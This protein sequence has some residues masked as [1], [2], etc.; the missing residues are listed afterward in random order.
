MQADERFLPAK[1]DSARIKYLKKSK[2]ILFNVSQF[3]VVLTNI[4]RKLFKKPIKPKNKW[5]QN[6]PLKNLCEYFGKEKLTH[7]LLDEIEKVYAIISSTSLILFK[8]CQEVSKNISSELAQPEASDENQ[9]GEY[10]V[11]FKKKIQ[12]SI[13]EIENV[14][15][16]IRQSSAESIQKIII[17]LDEAF[18]KAGTIELLKRNFNPD[19]IKNLRGEVSSII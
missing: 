14:E 18:Q 19:K 5:Q 6:I 7:L 4:F 13:S 1:D 3:P 11:V 16:S 12:E 8:A 2:N 9:P 15:I 17:Q 10:S